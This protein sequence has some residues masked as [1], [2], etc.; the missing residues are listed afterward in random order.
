MLRRIGL[1]KTP[2]PL[3]RALESGWNNS[4]RHWVAESPSSTLNQKASVPFSS[5]SHTFPNRRG[6]PSASPAGGN[7]GGGIGNDRWLNVVGSNCHL[8][9]DLSG[10]SMIH[11][12][13][14]RPSSVK[15]GLSARPSKLG[16]DTCHR[17]SPVSRSYTVTPKDGDFIPLE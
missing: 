14:S 4:F 5:S 17:R 8:V 7:T 15:I 3:G 16:G 6:G 11:E 12:K 2:R 10:V 13:E 9:C 1:A